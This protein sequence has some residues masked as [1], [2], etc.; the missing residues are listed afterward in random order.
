[1]AKK[2]VVGM[3]FAFA[4]V[5]MAV[6]T[7]AGYTYTNTYYTSSGS[8]SPVTV[9]SVSIATDATCTLDMDTRAYI[10]GT[11]FSTQ[12]QW[13]GPVN[14]LITSS[15]RTNQNTMSCTYLGGA[16]ASTSSSG[17][18]EGYAK[19]T[20]T[21]TSQDIIQTTRQVC[22]H[23]NRY[24]DISVDARSDIDSYGNLPWRYGSF[25][26]TSVINYGLTM[27]QLLNASQCGSDLRA[28]PF[29]NSTRPFS[30]NA[31]TFLF[32]GHGKAIYMFNSSWLGNV[33]YKLEDMQIEA[34]MDWG[35]GPRYYNYSV[36][37][38]DLEDQTVSILHSGAGT[39][40]FSAENHSVAG[41]SGELALPKNRMHAIVYEVVLYLQNTNAFIDGNVGYNLT[42]PH[43]FSIIIDGYEPNWD[44]TDWGACESGQRT[45]ECTD[46]N[47]IAPNEIEVE[48]CFEVPV[49]D[50][51]LGFEE[52]YLDTASVCDIDIS[53]S[54]CPYTPFDRTIRMPL[55]WSG[56]SA[57]YTTG[58]LKRNYIQLT[59]EDKTEGEFSLKMF[60]TPPKDAEPVGS[61]TPVCGNLT[62]GT[63]PLVETP[64]NETTYVA[65]NVS[66]DSPYVQL[67]LD[68]KT[69]DNQT[70][71]YDHI[72]DVLMATRCNL[73]PNYWLLGVK[74]GKMCYSANCNDTVKGVYSVAVADADTL[75][76]LYE[77]Q[78]EATDTWEKGKILDLSNMG[79]EVGRNYSI[80]IAIEEDD[81]QSR[82]GNCVL[83]D[84][85]RVTYTASPLLSCTDYCDCN[86]N[87]QYIAT[88]LNNSCVFSPREHYPECVEQCTGSEES[89]Q[90]ALNRQP[91]CDGT[92][93]YYYDFDRDEWLTIID[94]ELCVIEQEQQEEED[95]L[96]S[97]DVNV[98]PEGSAYEGFNFLLS[99]LFIAFVLNVII[100]GVVAVGMGK[101][102]DDSQ[103]PALV[104]LIVFAVTALVLAFIGLYPPVVTALLVIFAG[105]GVAVLVKGAMS[106][107]G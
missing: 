23:T 73:D 61:T 71:Q 52:F 11:G 37:L 74:D 46:L 51:N 3:A 106:G 66:F 47:G 72:G 17:I 12:T 65:Q 88:S 49:E 33:T 69:C 86:T 36:Y 24:F 15:V 27:A 90:A 55:G 50:I 29:I 48:S 4:F 41:V 100:A 19:V 7:V 98:V 30:F 68:V 78:T 56:S 84:R 81:L 21:G 63:P 99:P 45:R 34:H 40:A 6:V 1:M 14:N 44:C 85:V 8:A 67:R 94:S 43:V 28:Y 91:Y 31:G 16:E 104:F 80:G 97:T 103:G 2:Y 26:S 83:F 10:N 70:V 76:I 77:Y 62:S 32:S 39:I 54:S 25:D 35:T 5:L 92:T 38:L 105:L 75:D 57:R 22:E 107:G 13:F 64:F 58:Q 93:R 20:H 95:A 96:T 79:F 60:Y 18:Y 89:G 59:S 102:S 87:T 53:L 9:R 82:Q 42:E 101:I